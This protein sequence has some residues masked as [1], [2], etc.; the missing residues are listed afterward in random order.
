[1]YIDDASLVVVGAGA[2]LPA[3]V[4]PG[5]VGAVQPTPATGGNIVAREPLP[6]P[7]ADGKI[8]YTVRRGD[9]LTHI[10]VRFG[11]TVARLK[12]LNGLTGY[13]PI[14]YTGQRLIIGP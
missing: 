5:N 4:A 13:S 3:S 1:V 7:D 9:T 14:I 2:A 6:A 8:Y 12:Q 11:T 10:A